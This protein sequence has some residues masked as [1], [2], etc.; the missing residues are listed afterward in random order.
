MRLQRLAQ[1]ICV[2]A[3]A[4]GILV[5]LGG[6]TATLP[7][8]DD[9][10][11]GIMLIP[12]LP[13]SMY[14]IMASVVC[15]GV[16]MTLLV[17]FIQRRRNPAAL[18]LQRSTESRQAP[19]Q[20]FLNMLLTGVLCVV[21]L[22]WLMQHGTA[23]FQWLEHWR[24]EL[25][26]LPEF[27]ATNTQTLVRQVDSPV[28]GYTLFGVVTLVY[29]GLAAL[30]LWI[31]CTDRGYGAPHS[32]PDDPHLRHVR[33]AVTAGLQALQQHS[34]PRQAIIACY[35][36]LEHL[37]EDYGVPAYHHLTP[38]EYMG[39]ALQGLALPEEA[40]AGLVSLFE[41]AR[42]S[43]HPLDDAARLAAIRHLGVL[44]EHLSAPA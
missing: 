3:M 17:S 10:V 7:L 32:I 39:T 31:L 44:K 11:Q 22:R 38:Q 9:Q 33:R 21:A 28:A 4:L 14:L 36:R 25:E 13:L 19:W 12:A 30:G 20:V 5:Y 37:L 29:G 18:L 15:L 8:G 42:Y 26:T 40:F 2:S 27:L 24:H 16:G 6:L 35:A 43:L 1:S 41:Q 23:F 34:D